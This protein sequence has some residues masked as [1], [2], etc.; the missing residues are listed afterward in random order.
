MGGGA[1]LTSSASCPYPPGSKSPSIPG[2]VRRRGGWLHSPARQPQQPDARRCAV[3]EGPCGRCLSQYAVAAAV[4]GI[5]PRRSCAKFCR[6]AGADL[7]MVRTLG[8]SPFGEVSAFSCTRTTGGRRS[9][10]HPPRHNSTG[11][12]RPCWSRDSP[13][14]LRQMTRYPGRPCAS[15]N[16]WP[17]LSGL[18]CRSVPKEERR[19]L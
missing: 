19:L 18:T 1:S 12:T 6:A 4:L 16:L 7:R 13:R 10:R 8:C 9:L 11:A 3:R 14:W 17:A 5:A 15:A 2:P